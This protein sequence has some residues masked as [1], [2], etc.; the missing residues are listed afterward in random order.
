M[1]APAP[2]AV[3]R[4]TRFLGI[5]VGTLLLA[6]FLWPGGQTVTAQ[7]GVTFFTAVPDADFSDVSPG[8]GV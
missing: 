1:R 8:D 3:K 4:W 6:A 7:E 2:A 5:S